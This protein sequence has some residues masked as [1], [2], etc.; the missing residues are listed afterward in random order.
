M[1]DG[2][3]EWLARGGIVHGAYKCGRVGGSKDR[4]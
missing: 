1:H 3:R 2:A 4:S